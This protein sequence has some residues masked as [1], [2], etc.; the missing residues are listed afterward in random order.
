MIRAALFT[1]QIYREVESRR[2][3]D[4]VLFHQYMHS[5][6]ARWSDWKKAVSRALADPQASM[7]CLRLGEP[8]QD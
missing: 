1:V 3:D 4:I 5:D 2:A 7:E 8:E 6:P